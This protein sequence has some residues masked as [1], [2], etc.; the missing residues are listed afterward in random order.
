MNDAPFSLMLALSKSLASFDTV[1]V[2]KAAVG[3]VTC[4]SI[5]AFSG[6]KFK[7]KRSVY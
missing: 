5:G 3:H 7:K 4:N 6:A 2:G 1:V